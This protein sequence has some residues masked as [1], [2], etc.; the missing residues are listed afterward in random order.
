MY[1]GRYVIVLDPGHYAKQPNIGVVKGYYEGVMTFALAGYYKTELEKYG[2]IVYPTRTN[3]NS[4]PSLYSRGYMCKAK[5]A[6][7]FLS[8]HSNAAPKEATKGAVVIYS[9]QR[10]ETADFAKDLQVQIAKTM[11]SKVYG[12]WAKNSETQPNI[13]KDY[14]GVLSGAVYYA[15]VKQAFILE[16]GM[17]TNTA[18]CTW[19]MNDAN[20]RK[21]AADMAL[22][23][24]KEYGLYK[25]PVPVDVKDTQI[26]ALTKQVSDLLAKVTALTAD[27]VALSTKIANAIKSLN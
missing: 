6:D 12:V 2:F 7:L 11:G 20:L 3:T 16:H 1:N 24:A 22:L 17:H 26:S 5:S 4:N 23:I 13:K 8:I 10:P 15:G 25:A 18:E 14:Y 27:K 19:L 21:M 9:V